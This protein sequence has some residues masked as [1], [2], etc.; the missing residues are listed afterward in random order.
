MTTCIPHPAQETKHKTKEGLDKA[1]NT[2]RVDIEGKA[3]KGKGR[4]SEPT[5]TGTA[6]LIG[7]GADE[8][9]DLFKARTKSC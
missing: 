3:G 5:C 7:D 4:G 2:R 1:V 8:A 6:G 9:G